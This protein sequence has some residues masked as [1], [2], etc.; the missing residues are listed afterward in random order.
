MKRII[1]ALLALLIT[2]TLFGG[3]LSSVTAVNG[4]QLPQITN[5]RITTANKKNLLKLTWDQQAGVDGFQIFRSTTGKSGTYEK[6]ATVRNKNAY[7]DKDLKNSTVYFYKVRAFLNQN[8]NTVFGPFAKT[9]L[10]TK[11]TSSYAK[12]K[13]NATI[14]FLENFY[15]SGTN[16]DE[17]IIKSHTDSYGTYDDPHYL[18]QY[19]GC[20][21]KEQ[22][23]KH[24]TKYVSSKVADTILKDKFYIIDGKLYIWFPAMGAESAMDLSKT[25]ISRCLFS[26]KRV[27]MQI[28]VF[29]EG[30][31]GYGGADYDYINQTLVF[32]NGRWV[33]GKETYMLDWVYPYW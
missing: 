30:A 19:K 20:R 23:K 4:A 2:L 28:G 15:S 12:K 1:S 22:L 27:S 17:M 31:E 14:K 11:I 16:F 26:D 33:F 9:N 24:L 10:S 6:I 7:V 3:E 13:F 18:F 32:E 29:W 8:G 5:L 21:T 25:K